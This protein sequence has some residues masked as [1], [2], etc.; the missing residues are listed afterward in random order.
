MSS[1]AGDDRDLRGAARPW[2]PGIRGGSRGELVVNG[3][4]FSKTSMPLLPC[5]VVGSVPGIEQNTTKNRQIG[6]YKPTDSLERWGFRVFVQCRV[7]GNGL[8]V[9][10]MRP[11]VG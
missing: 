4:A 1:Q 10:P 8:N 3:G 5:R 9:G 7:V 11:N 6:R 2:A